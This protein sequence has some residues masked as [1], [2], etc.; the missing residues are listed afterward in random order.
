LEG[1][2]KSAYNSRVNPFKIVDPK[3]IGI[4]NKM[5]IISDGDIIANE[6]SEGKPLELGVDKWSNQRYGNK[7]FLLNTINYL[8]D[9]TGLINI[10]SKRVKIDYLDKQKAYNQ[11]NI[12]QLTNIL[13]P[14]IVLGVFG[15]IF[16]YIRKKKYR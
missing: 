6:L 5:V 14:L 7:E 8:L 10:R 2:F 12:W 1:T 11:S 15:F 4:E 16:N 13:L 9:E 3:E